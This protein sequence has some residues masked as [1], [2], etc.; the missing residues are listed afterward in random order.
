MVAV[1]YKFF[2]L[3]AKIFMQIFWVGMQKYLANLT[4][5]KLFKILYN[6]FKKARFTVICILAEVLNI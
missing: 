1:Y 2:Q 4:T 3:S 5:Y 6:P